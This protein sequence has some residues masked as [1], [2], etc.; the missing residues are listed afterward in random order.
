MSEKSE[1][2]PGKDMVSRPQEIDFENAMDPTGGS[3]NS[4]E[5]GRKRV[6]KE[7]KAEGEDSRVVDQS[8]SETG[9]SLLKKGKKELNKEKKRKEKSIK[10]QRKESKK[11]K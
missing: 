7:E 8:D 2:K 4:K 11:K 3:K 6:V 1:L 9:K 5:K 10:K